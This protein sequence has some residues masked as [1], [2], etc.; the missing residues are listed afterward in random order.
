MSGGNVLKN[1]T[2]AGTGDQMVM[3][4]NNFQ[5]VPLSNPAGISI[6]LGGMP[7]NNIVPI[8]STVMTNSPINP[9]S[10]LDL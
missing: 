3:T 10:K 2:A 8:T 4:V 7:S 6:S 9:S 1:K 5:N